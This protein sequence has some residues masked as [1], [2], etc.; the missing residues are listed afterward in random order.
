MSWLLSMALVIFG[1]SASQGPSKAGRHEDL[2]RAVV[3]YHYFCCGWGALGGATTS[4]SRPSDEA[5]ISEELL[6]SQS[7]LSA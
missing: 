2:M 5:S 4:G 7:T 1:G 3:R 6:N